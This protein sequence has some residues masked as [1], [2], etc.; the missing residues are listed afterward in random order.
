M[1]REDRAGPTP[2]AIAPVPPGHLLGDLK[3]LEGILD[4][5]LGAAVDK[6][7]GLGQ[8]APPHPPGGLCGAAAGRRRG[9][10]RGIP[11]KRPSDSASPFL[12]VYVLGSLWQLKPL[13]SLEDQ[14]KEKKNI[15]NYE[16]Q[17]A[18]NKHTG[19]STV[20]MPHTNMCT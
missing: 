15:L 11:C 12:R 1:G 9:D 20:T 7:E 5:T 14:R 8:A 17:Q 4:L 3:V 19:T 18:G 2:A 10:A 16:N 13:Y 6:G